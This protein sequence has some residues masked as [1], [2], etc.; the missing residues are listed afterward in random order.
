M[1]SSHNDPDAYHNE[2]PQREIYLEAYSIGR[3]SVTNRE[4]Q[5]FVKDSGH[6][7]P[8]HWRGQDY[9]DGLDDHPVV[10]LNWYDAQAYCA[11][12]S[13]ET[14]KR[15]RLPSEA[16]WEKAAR[17][18]DGRIWPWEGTW[19]AGKCN[20]R[21]SEID[22]TTPVGLYSPEGDS[23]YGVADM[24]GNVWEWCSDE[25]RRYDRILRGGSFLDERRLVRCAY[26]FGRRPESNDKSIGFRVFLANV[27]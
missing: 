11:W 24:S 2:V 21:E 19:E 18:I 22:E 14:G 9:P 3:Y 8:S 12:L 4:Y 20:S 7:P 23:P 26:R 25:Y 15:Y 6:T 17:G 5:Y 27:E 10:H 16:E 13:Q 1:G